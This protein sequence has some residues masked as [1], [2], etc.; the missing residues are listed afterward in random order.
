[1]SAA[2]ARLFVYYRVPAADLRPVIEAA[3]AL[4]ATLRARHPG[5]EADLLRRP[6]LRDGDATLMETYAAA[7]GIDDALA[8]EIERLAADAGLPRPRHVEVFEPLA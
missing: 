8:A 4:Q 7:G 3:R 5:L 1:M 2:A 6:E